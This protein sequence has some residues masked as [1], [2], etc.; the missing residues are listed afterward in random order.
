[1]GHDDL[2][3]E[4]LFASELDDDMMMG[5]DSMEDEELDLDDEDMEDEELDW[6]TKIWKMTTTVVDTIRRW[7]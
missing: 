4:D 3:G 6:M 1:M 2:I 7:N 5:E